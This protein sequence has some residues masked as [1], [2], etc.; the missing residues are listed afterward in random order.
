LEAA[1]AAAH[2]ETQ[3]HNVLGAQEE[4]AAEVQE[5]NLT[6]AAME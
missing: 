4:L 2:L 3:E 5:V 1:E 6:L